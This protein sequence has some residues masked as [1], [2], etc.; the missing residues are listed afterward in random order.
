MS[1]H[2]K[3]LLVLAVVTVVGLGPGPERQSAAG[4]TPRSG[5]ELAAAL[6]AAETEVKLACAPLLNW[7]LPL[8]VAQL[9]T[10]GTARTAGQLPFAPVVP[11]FG[12]LPQVVQVS[13]PAR[14]VAADRSVAFVYR[15]PTGPDFP[16]NGRVLVKESTA[17]MTTE[18]LRAIAADPA[19]SAAVTFRMI[20]VG[21]TPALLTTT[22]GVGRV[23]FV[24]AGVEYDVTGPAVS[25]AEVQR[26]AALTG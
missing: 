17:T 26:L 2:W 20:R 13:D 24:R 1:R 19:G 21:S 5:A 25:P 6:A 12:L 11:R 22:H 10:V 7:D 3:A 23:Q 9:A 4:P 14:V 16:T 8:D 18:T 15:F